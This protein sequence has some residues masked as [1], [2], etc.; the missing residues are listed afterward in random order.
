MISAITIKNFLVHSD[1]TLKDIPNIN[2]VIG[3]NDTGKTG[4]LKLL[5][6]SIKALEIYS[7]KTQ[8]SEVSFKK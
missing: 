8:A 7:L 2:V 5:Y 3:K 6:S 4:L 1:L